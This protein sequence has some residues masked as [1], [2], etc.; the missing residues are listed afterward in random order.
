MKNEK[1]KLA[2]RRLNE[3]QQEQSEDMTVITTMSANSIKGGLEGGFTCTGSF[4]CDGYSCKSFT[5]N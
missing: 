3:F 1:L 4:S 2:L 5:S